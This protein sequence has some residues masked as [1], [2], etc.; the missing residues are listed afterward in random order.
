MTQEEAMNISLFTLS[1]MKNCWEE[2]QNSMAN[3]YG[4]EGMDEIEDEGEVYK[5]FNDY[6]KKRYDITR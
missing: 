5:T 1:D 6:I 3:E 2:S 4:F